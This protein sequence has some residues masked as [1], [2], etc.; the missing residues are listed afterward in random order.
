M[1]DIRDRYL[2][3]YIVVEQDSGPSPEDFK[4]L[5]VADTNG[6][7][8]LR[9]RT[10]L[11]TFGKRNLNGRL[12]H[13]QHLKAMIQDPGVQRY[14]IRGFPGENGHPV[15]AVGQVTLERIF[16]IDPNN[17]SHKILEFQWENDNKLCGII[18]TLDEGVGSPGYRFMRNILQKMDPCFSLRSVVPQRK[19]PDG[20]ID[21]TGP[22]R[23]V[24]FDRVHGPSHE[25]AFIDK[26]IQIKEIITKPH[27]E[28]VMESFSNFVMDR[29]D[30]V[31]R[32]VDGMQPAMES[33]SIEKNGT[34]GVNTKEGRIFIAPEQKFRAEYNDFIKNF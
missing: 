26:S 9:F 31:N 17:T 25:E 5:K 28:T 13:G 3:Y 21:V 24:T 15:P 30:K 11:Q 18:E 1:T 34:I 19:N 8:F 4:L 20:T 33:V 6:L 29:S 32:I 7:N 16:T 12:W 14:L 23:L 27:F 2:D 22:G 10:C